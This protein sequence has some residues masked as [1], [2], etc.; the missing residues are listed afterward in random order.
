M[1]KNYSLINFIKAYYPDSN[2]PMYLFS[3]EKCIFCMPEQDELTYPPFQYLQELF[4]GSERITYCTTEYG[5]MFCSLRLNHCKNGYIVFGPVTTV[6]YSDSDSDLQRLYKD[7]MV[8][9][10]SRSDFNS[11]LRQIPC[12]SLSSL[13]KKCIFLN[14]CLHEELLSLEQLT[15]IGHVSSENDVMSDTSHLLEETYQKKENEQ[16][17][18]TYIL[19][20]EILKLVRTGDCEGF[21]KFAYSESNFHIGV[22]GSTALRQLKNNIIITTTLCTR[23]AIDGGLD[24]DTAYQLSDYFIQSSERLTSADRLT[25]LL[26]KISYTFAEKVAQ[27][28][29]P[30]STDE[31]MQKAIRYI[32]QN[33]NQHLTVGN[34]A[35]Y[36]GFSKSYF[37]AYFKKTLGFSVSAFIL[38]CK[39]EEGKELL[40][41]TDKSIST[42]SEFLC[43]SSQSHFHTAFK[44]Q[45]GMTPSEYRKSTNG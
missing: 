15:S 11:F 9:N 4:S 30:V 17:N 35:D 18:R 21:K 3:D 22:T 36:V 33:T 13:L 12:L 2:I 43:F 23:A 6:P 8:S 45:F 27:A 14:Y 39:L 16:H 32:Q 40:Q 31:R 34:V 28:K 25:D 1:K 20:E 44:K 29:T 10:D 24:Y 5:I 19:E 42:I 41:Y 37:S 26:G 38:R 7:Y